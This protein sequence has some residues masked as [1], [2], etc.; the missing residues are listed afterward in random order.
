M[1]L[2]FKSRISI[3]NLII[4]SLDLSLLI[5]SGSF[6][7]YKANIE[8][9]WISVFGILLLFVGF[10]QFTT[11]IFFFNLSEETLQI[12]FPIKLYNSCHNFKLNEIKE[13]TFSKNFRSP[14]ITIH[15]INSFDDNSF[16]INFPESDIH[17]FIIELNNLGIKTNRKDI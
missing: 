5:I 3:P 15:K 7:I 10:F 1:T 4:S 13:I 8:S 17:K 12:R 9:I 14:L 6:L 2:K 16:I 11:Y